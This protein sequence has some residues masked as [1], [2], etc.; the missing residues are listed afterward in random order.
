M[1][2]R[3]LARSLCAV[4][5]SASLSFGLSAQAA[6]TTTGCGI[7]DACT[8]AELENGGTISIDDVLFD[9]W[10]S[11]NVGAPFGGLELGTINVVGSSDASSVRL[12]FSFAPSLQ[13]N[14]STFAEF[15]IDFGASVSPSRT[16]TGARV[17]LG[18]ASLSSSG[19]SDFAAVQVGLTSEGEVGEVVISSTDLV[20]NASFD[21]GTLTA[22]SA[23][24]DIQGEAEEDASANLTG[25][26]VVFFLEGEL[27]P[28]AAIPVPGAAL[29]MLSG[30]AGAGV[31]Q[32]RRTKT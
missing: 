24:I 20:T 26:S 4:A 30:L 2:Y 12:D 19:N 8:V 22:L 17:S 1:E 28:D 11:E 9:S 18:S 21:L 15:V 13:L 5:A 6:V 32:R 14:A 29:L 10:G 25:F 27:Q 7:D 23:L 3:K 31:L 16:I